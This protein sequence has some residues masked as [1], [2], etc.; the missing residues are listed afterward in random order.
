[1]NSYEAK[2]EAKRERLEAAADRAEARSDDAYRK[3]DLRE[4]V[5]GIPFG[6]PIIIGSSGEARHRTA[7]KRMQKRIDEL[8]KVMKSNGFRWAPSQEAWQRQLTNNAIWSGKMA[9]KELE[10]LA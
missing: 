8:R 5:S 6:Q 3:S 2:Q 9:I 4:E 10:A 1:M 7:I